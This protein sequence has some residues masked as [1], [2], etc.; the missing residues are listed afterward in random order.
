MKE[1]KAHIT[2]WP[3][4]KLGT[5]D[6]R[7]YGTT[8][9]WRDATWGGIW[10]GEGSSI[11]QVD[12]F[13]Q[14]A[15]EALA[16]IALPVIQFFPQS[17][18]YNWLDG[19]GPR[20]QRPNTLLCWGRFRGHK[21]MEAPNDVGTDEFVR[22]CNLV[23][24][25]PFFDTNEFDP[26]GSKNWVEYCN[27]DGNTRYA[28]LRREHGRA[29][30]YGVRYWHVYGWGNLDPVAHAIEYRKFAALARLVDPS[31]R[32]IGSAAGGAEWVHQFLN[33]LEQAITNEVGGTGLVDYMA[34]MHYFGV[35]MKDIDF[36]DQE[37]YRLLANTAGLDQEL[38]HHDTTLRFYSRRRKPWGRDWLDEAY[39]D[40]P[41][42]AE[43]IGMV[44]TEWGVNWASQ[45]C[46]LRDAIAAA[47]I[48]D[49]FHRWANRIDMAMAYT[50]TEGQA[51][52][53]TEGEA[54]WVT[55]TYHLFDMY[56][57]HRAK[58][59]VKLEVRC[60]TIATGEETQHR[61]F[62]ASQ[63]VERPNELP[64]ISSSA[65]MSSDGRSMVVS[66]TNRHLTDQIAVCI[67]IRGD[68]SPTSGS[69]RLLTSADVRDH[70][71]AAHPNRVKPTE[72]T[73]LQVGRDFVYTLLPHSV[74]V[75]ELEMARH[76]A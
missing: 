46:P 2:V 17:P 41:L 27:Y 43:E 19:V 65:S 72:S 52:I 10:A 9:D 63:T 47:G 74:A 76:T 26:V 31:I 28:R 35:L 15:I 45:I 44:I 57:R 64:V 36:T 68:Q 69:V 42:D 48:L 55:P 22:F 32:V 54:M 73:S 13:R 53:Q 50:L 58:E 67:A 61:D 62:F 51:L 30:P 1:H 4:Q 38:T 37:Y 75:I 49:T 56:R 3:E 60:E 12:G 39:Q 25:E 20:D 40:Q 16:A 6:P 29:S 66:L 23:G 14:D 8:W 7:L 5:I 34:H 11:P 71:D 24:A 59:S 21:P 18:S 33:T 70:N